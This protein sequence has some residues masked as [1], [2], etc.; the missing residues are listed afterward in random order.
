MGHSIHRRIRVEHCILCASSSIGTYRSGQ[1][2]TKAPRLGLGQRW[3][4]DDPLLGYD[5]IAGLVE[6]GSGLE[7]KEEEYFMEMK[8]FRKVNHAECTRPHPIL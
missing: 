8:E 6:A 3:A 4:G 2:C 5:W 1:P 7:E